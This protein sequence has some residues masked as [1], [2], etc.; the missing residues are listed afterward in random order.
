MDLNTYLYKPIN[1]A[2]K[3]SRNSDKNSNKI[4]FYYFID[5]Q[6]SLIKKE[7]SYTIFNSIHPDTCT[8]EE[9]ALIF[10]RYNSFIQLCQF[11]N[12]S[13]YKDFKLIEELHVIFT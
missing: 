11:D 8:D 2:T 4:I 6:F 13:F 1:S 10:C 12:N 3:E 9:F 5:C 7:N